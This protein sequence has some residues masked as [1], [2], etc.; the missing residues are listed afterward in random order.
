MFQQCL[1]YEI[2]EKDKTLTCG[3]TH[4]K[5]QYI[6]NLSTCYRTYEIQEEDKTL[7]CGHTHTRNYNISEIYQRVTEQSTLR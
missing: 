3:H 1:T 6:R 7:T 2:Q 5:L 4:T